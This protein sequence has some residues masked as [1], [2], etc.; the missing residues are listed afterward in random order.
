MPPGAPRPPVSAGHTQATPPGV[1]PEEYDSL[2]QLN[3][4]TLSEGNSNTRTLY[5]QQRSLMY[6]Q[7]HKLY[8]RPRHNSVDNYLPRTLSDRNKSSHVHEGKISP[9]AYSQS[10]STAPRSDIGTR[11]G[12]NYHPGSVQTMGVFPVLMEN[13]P[14]VDVTYFP[15]MQTISLG[16]HSKTV[17]III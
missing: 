14:H 8:E 13:V 15:G 7:H 10:F 16:P 1:H 4:R 3:P 9:L 17:Y 6:H 5:L 11:S 2:Q 12:V